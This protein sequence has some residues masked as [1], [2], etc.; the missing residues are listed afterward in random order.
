MNFI[1]TNLSIRSTVNSRCYY[2]I[3]NKNIK[4]WYADAVSYLL[5]NLSIRILLHYVDVYF[6][7]QFINWLCFAIHQ[8]TV[9][10]DYYTL[11]F[12]FSALTVYCD[13]KQ[14]KKVVLFT[15]NCYCTLSKLINYIK[16]LLHFII[17]S[18]LGFFEFF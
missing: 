12:I 3:V 11:L 9:N 10:G 6:V 2:A 17:H 16:F 5:V 7:S 13:W 18:L 1:I 15:S 4:I 8:L 14:T